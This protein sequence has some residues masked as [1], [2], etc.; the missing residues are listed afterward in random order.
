MSSLKN[1]IVGK[2]NKLTTA[3]CSSVYPPTIEFQARGLYFATKAQPGDF[4]QWDV[5]TYEV[6]SEQQIKLSTAN[7]AV[8]TYQCSLEKDVLTFVDQN[9]CRFQYR[10]EP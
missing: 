2:W 10:R 8:I 7:D 9:N 5:G 1:S 3:Q 6:V 4:A